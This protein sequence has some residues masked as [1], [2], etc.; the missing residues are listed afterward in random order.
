[1]PKLLRLRCLSAEEEQ[2][3]GRLARSRTAPVRLVERV[4]IIGLAAQGRRVPA[5]AAELG[6]SEPVVRR[7]LERFN[8]GGVAGLADAPRSG[9]PVTYPPETVGALVAASLTNPAD[10]GLPFGSWTLDRLAAYLHEHKGIAM[11]RS[12]IGEIL[13]SEGLRWRQQETWFG[14]RPDPA[15]AEKRGPS[16]RSTPRPPRT[17][18]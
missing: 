5:I 13:Q 15:F 9:R 16:S 12:R 7:W 3:I 4:R 6:I 8:A 1:V 11:K 14:E 17:A 2:T 18:S 10:L